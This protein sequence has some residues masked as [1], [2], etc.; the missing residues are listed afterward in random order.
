MN[1]KN[2]GELRTAQRI[3]D[4][5]YWL[6]LLVGIIIGG[7]LLFIDRDSS[8][9]IKLSAIGASLVSAVIF[10][11]LVL[12]IFSREADFHLMLSLRLIFKEYLLDM[13]QSISRLHVPSTE[14]PPTDEFDPDFMLDL[15][16]DLSGSSVFLYRGSSGKW[17]APYINY[18]G[19]PPQE[20]KVIVLDPDDDL[21]VHQRAADRM[22]TKK[23]AHRHIDEL[24]RELRHEICMA[25]VSLYDARHRSTI[26]VFLLGSAASPVGIDLTDKAVYV[27]LQVTGQG[28]AARNPM[29]YRYEKD[30][31]AYQN[32]YVELIRQSRIARVTIKFDCN[33]NGDDLARA[34]KT[35][36][37]DNI[38]DDQIDIL[39]KDAK[40]FEQR[41]VT[42]MRS[43][44]R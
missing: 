19:K 44:A 42:N 40:E 6:I 8:L 14:Y 33:S 39:R 21:A 18:C 30:S 22:R 13:V 15:M 9:A 12:L 1:Y 43:A 28:P 4:Y 37:M 41:F 23:N 32:Y 26:E 34:F 25:F 36:G 20:I 16:D 11:T 35:I 10:G 2:L 24:V 5:A 27:G 31:L 29:S 17:I 38:T 7:I 3:R